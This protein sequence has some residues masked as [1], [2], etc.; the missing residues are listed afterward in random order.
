[1]VSDEVLEVLEVWWYEGLSDCGWVGKAVAV[2]AKGRCQ[3]FKEYSWVC[4]SKRFSIYI[5]TSLFS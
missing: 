4:I 2:E 1:M 5:S 3:T